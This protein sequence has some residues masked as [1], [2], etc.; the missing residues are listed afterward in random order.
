MMLSSSSASSLDHSFYLVLSPRYLKVFTFSTGL[1]F[2]LALT[3]EYWSKFSQSQFKL[4]FI[5][6]VLDTL[7]WSL[8]F[9]NISSIKH[10]SVQSHLLCVCV[11]GGGGVRFPLLLFGSSVFWVEPCK[12]LT[13]VFIV[14]KPGIICTFL[15]HSGSPQKMLNALFNLIWNTQKSKWTI[16]FVCQCKMFLSTEKVLQQ[17]NEDQP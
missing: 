4:K 5:A 10:S 1:Q 11:W 3:F 9:L 16:F 12:I 8:N 2:C 17:I 7:T 13:Q 14:L 6:L 15:I